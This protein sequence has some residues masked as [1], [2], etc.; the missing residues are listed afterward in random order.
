MKDIQDKEDIK[1]FV[2]GFYKKVRED[3]ILSV[4][5]NSKIDSDKWEQ[6]LNR[7]YDFWNTVLFFQQEY[8][9]NPFS[10]HATL[11]VDEKHF[12][13]WIS[14]FHKTIDENFEGEIAESTKMRANR[15]PILFQKKLE[16]IQ[17][18]PNYKSIM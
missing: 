8:K 16:N 12:N 18:N 5:F 9:G 1:I 10:K 3:K 4:I 17:E 13:Q 14:L 2:D 11:A 15:M 6:H 7:M